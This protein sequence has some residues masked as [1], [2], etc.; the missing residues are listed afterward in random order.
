M[1]TAC[2]FCGGAAENGPRHASNYLVPASGF[3]SLQFRLVENLLGVAVENRSKYQQLYYRDY[4]SEEEKA[5][6]AAS[7]AGPSLLR[8]VEV[9][10]AGARRLIGCPATLTWSGL[11]AAYRRPA[12]GDWVLPARPQ[13]WLERTPGLAHGDYVFWGDYGRAVR[14]MLQDQ[15]QAAAE[16]RRATPRATAV[17]CARAPRGSDARR[18]GRRARASSRIQRTDLDDVARSALLQACE[19]NE[20]EFANL[21]DADK[22]EVQRKDGVRSLSHK[23]IQGAMMIHLY[24]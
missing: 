12:R 6:L 15:R 5:A 17:P 11:L 18:P 23:A 20:D 8:L 14:R 2:L 4:F 24:R 3:Q 9:G 10:T 21:L 19:K 16:V 22:Y 13:K 7:E 1:L